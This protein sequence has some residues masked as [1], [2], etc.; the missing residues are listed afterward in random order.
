MIRVA[1]IIGK[2]DTGGKKNLVMEYY[3]HIDRSIVQFDF[4]CDSDSND[5]PNDEIH[6]LGGRVYIIPP[7]QNI[8]RNMSMIRY[9]FRKNN[10]LIVHA[11]NSTMNIF[12]MFVAK[13]IGIPVRISE[14]ISMAHWSDRK[15]IIKVLLR[16]MAGLFANH[17]MS[18]GIECGKW[19]F[20]KSRMDSGKVDVFKSVVDTDRFS[21]DP[22]VRKQTR[23]EFGWSDDIL[24]GFAGRF[25]AQ[26]N[27]LF[28][29]KVFD[30]ILKK[31]RRAR[32]CLIGDGE[33][34]ETMEHLIKQ[35]K[36][37]HKVSFLG[38]RDDV[39]RFLNA[40]DGF[41]LPSLYEGLTVVGLEA[42]CCG[43]PV[44][45]STEIDREVNVCGLGRFM[46]LKDSPEIWANKILMTINNNIHKRRDYSK[47]VFRA[48]FDSINESRRLQN[49]YID[50]VK[51]IR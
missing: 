21:F 5:I 26:K 17:Y 8:L 29:V 24:I 38:R 11:Y 25:T 15:T 7:Y 46:S 4:I 27:P 33:L 44:F 20:G 45:F 10:Y 32:L 6:K 16:P 36:I 42:A 1:V 34:R 12:P 3:R 14:S 47:E 37:Q 40:M 49:Y 51:G 23:E 19:Q 18:C 30:A 28:I 13:E 43:L 35:L 41:L 9:L 22:Y 48:G 31:E 2:M 39:Q 50:A